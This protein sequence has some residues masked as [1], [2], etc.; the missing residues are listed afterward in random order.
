[1]HLQPSGK[2]EWIRPAVGLYFTDEPASLHPML[3]ELENDSALKIPAGAKD[4]QVSDTFTLPVDL[5]LLAIYPHAHYLGKDMKAVA[6]FPDGSKKTLLHISNWD[7][8]WQAVYSYSHPVALPKGTAVEMLYRYDNSRENLRNP[9]SP[10][11]E[12]FGGNRAK[13]EMAHLW[14]QVLPRGDNGPGDPR[15]IL[16][17][18]LS[19]HEVER[20]P[21]VFEAQYDLAAMLTESRTNSGSNQWLCGGGADSAERSGGEECAGLGGAGG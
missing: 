11:V 3:L 4:F 13:D 17:E 16:Q 6:S 1:M 14:L 10:P 18:A 5:D 12:V 20:D 7:L 21:S 8:N 9:D 19:R 2:Q 15:L